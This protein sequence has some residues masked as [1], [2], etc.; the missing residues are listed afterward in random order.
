MENETVYNMLSQFELL[1]YKEEILKSSKPCIRLFPST[2]KDEEIPI[3]AS[4][5]G[6]DPDLPV[7]FN[8]PKYKNN[9]FSFLA[10]I[11]C[12][13]ISQYDIESILPEKGFIYFFYECQ[14]FV[15]G[16][17][18]TDKNYWKVMYYDGPRENLKR[19][20][21]SQYLSKGNFFT[22]ALVEEKLGVSFA[23]LDSHEL[24]NMEW[25]D[26]GDSYIQFLEYFEKKVK[27]THHLLG[28]PK[29][30]QM[31]VIEEVLPLIQEFKNNKNISAEDLVLLLQLDTDETNTNMLWGDEGIIHFFIT[32]EDLKERN[33]QDVW[34][35]LQSK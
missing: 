8:I 17:E 10:Q 12:Q 34:L 31:N 22:P 30:V 7:G 16:I 20:P 3:G 35:S 5:F 9:T 18:I 27:S 6:G 32:K 4:K 33:F 23:D 24:E 1:D 11:N 2:C 28:Q 29:V 13:D 14:N 26:Y 25:E 19:T 21:I 15:S